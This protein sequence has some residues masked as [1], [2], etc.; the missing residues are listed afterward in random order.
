MDP[1]KRSFSGPLT[2]PGAGEGEC[3][4]LASLT[5]GAVLTGTKERIGCS[6]VL[7]SQRAQCVVKPPLRAKSHQ[8]L[9]RPCWPFAISISGFRI[10]GV[11]D[12]LDLLGMKMSLIDCF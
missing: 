10:S 5:P 9:F 2:S 7:L 6:L 4:E 12:S 11:M 8:G 1:T 3:D